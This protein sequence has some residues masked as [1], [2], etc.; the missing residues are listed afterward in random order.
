MEHDVIDIVP[1]VI[2][3]YDPTLALEV[4]DKTLDIVS[5]PVAQLAIFPMCNPL[6]PTLLM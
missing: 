2:K 6:L 1:T 3:N 5:S 4:I